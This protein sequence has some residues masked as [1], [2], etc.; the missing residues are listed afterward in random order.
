MKN[1]LALFCFILLNAPTAF[2]EGQPVQPQVFVLDLKSLAS[3]KSAIKAK[4]ATVLPAYQQL[5]RDADKALKFGPVSV[6]EKTTDPPSGDRHDYMSLAPYFWP[7]PTKP[8]GLPYIRKDGQT[9]PEVKEYKDK[10]YLPKLCESVYTLGLAYYFSEDKVYAVH[11]AELLRVWFL[12]AAT[13]M[14]P[15]LNFGQAIKGVNTGRGAGM[16]DTRHFIKLID[17]IGLLKGSSAWKDADQKGMQQWFASFLQW[18]QTS[19]IGIS[20]MNAPN[21]HGAWYD[22]QRLSIAMF[23]DSTDLARRIISNAQ[24]R[25]DKQMDESGRFPL[26]MERTIALHYNVFV[27]EAFFNIAKVAGK[28]GIDF[29]NYT[30]PSGKSLKKGFDALHPYFAGT[31]EWDGQQIK[32]YEFDESYFLLQEGDKNFNCRSC[33]QELKSLAGD[34]AA[35]LRINLLY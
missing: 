2:A 23:I 25:L 29:W 35:K 9:N 31:K 11:A 30:T 8:G 24:N 5:I 21:N 10:D 18:M 3:N 20:E 34:K 33:A 7:D 4:Q 22:A 15:N 26:E 1:L 13:R 12:D 28:L 32:P 17:G 27:L 19:R 14:N 6:M 16:I